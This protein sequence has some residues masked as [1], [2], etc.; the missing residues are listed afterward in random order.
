MPKL[1]KEK[2]MI[3]ILRNGS[4]IVALWGIPLFFNV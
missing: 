3:Q 1:L 4:Q 2:T